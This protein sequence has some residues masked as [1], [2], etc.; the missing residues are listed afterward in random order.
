MGFWQPAYFQSQQSLK[1]LASLFLHHLTAVASFDA[2]VK[3]G[4]SADLDKVDLT[5][6]KLSLK[7][8]SSSKVRAIS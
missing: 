8:T 2:S 6:S 7:L 3:A 1:V 5:D 4:F